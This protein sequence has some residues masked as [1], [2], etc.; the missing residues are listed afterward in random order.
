[1]RAGCAPEF[2]GVAQTLE[3]SVDVAIVQITPEGRVS[4]WWGASRDMFGFERHDVL[5]RP[6]DELFTRSDR[7][8]GVVALGLEL[9][10]KAGHS[11]HERWHVRPDG[12]RFWASGVV[13]AQRDAEGACAGYVLLLRD[14]TDAHIRQG[15]L[16]NR[17]MALTE[18]LSHRDAHLITLVHELRNAVSP[19]LTAAALLRD[20]QLPESQRRAL[21]VVLRQP[22]VLKRL[23]D[24]AAGSRLGASVRPAFEPVV[25]Q[26]ALAAAVEAFREEAARRRQTL[27]L[28]MPP[29]PVRMEADWS[30]LQQLLFNLLSNAV[31]YTPD[32]GCVTVSLTVDARNATIEVEDTGIGIE[33]DRIERIF[34]LFT[35]ESTGT[36]APGVGVGLAVVK[37]IAALHGG[38]VEARSA[39]P[40]EGSV[41]AVRLPFQS[42]GPALDD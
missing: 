35:R 27:Q 14:R 38:L 21:D 26:D 31:K 8:A 11:D 16:A 6:V 7:D 25:L 29:I 41:F 1:M 40:G 32:D 9:A 2:E 10:R 4:G 18:E 28:L 20:A 17:A 12:A 19:M 37:D 33:P 23:L 39:G 13:I 22:R 30:K 36:A 5:G 3:R 24:E 42:A 15:A 34:E